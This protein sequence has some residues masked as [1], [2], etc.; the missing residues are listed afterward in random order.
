[1]RELE[2]GAIDPPADLCVADL[3]FI[4]LRTVAPNLL[5]LTAPA[6]ELVLLVKPQ[7][8]AGRNH[9]GKGGIVRDP[10]VHA[11]VL[12][13]VVGAFDALGLGVRSLVTSPLRGA[14][15]N[16]EFFVH[17]RRGRSEVDEA[18]IERVVAAAHVVA[19]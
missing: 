7:F 10:V 1:M 13:E 8:E 15:G 9:V 14:D 6:A 3:S 18:E 17:A 12:R 4:S 19:A 5:A 2:A 11:S 16:I